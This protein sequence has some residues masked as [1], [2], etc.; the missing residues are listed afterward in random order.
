MLST[1]SEGNSRRV[2]WYQLKVCLRRSELH[3]ILLSL[4]VLGPLPSLPEPF[5]NV[6]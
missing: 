5:Q 3:F 4:H 6:H 2:L 1:L